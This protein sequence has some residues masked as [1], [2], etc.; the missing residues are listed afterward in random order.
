MEVSGPVT[1]SKLQLQSVRQLQQGQILLPTVPAR[2]QTRAS[3]P[4]QATAVRFLTHCITMGAPAAWESLLVSG[5]VPHQK[6]I[7]NK[8]NRIRRQ[9]KVFRK[10]QKDGKQKMVQTT[11]RSQWLTQPTRIHEED[12]SISGLD[13]CVKDSALS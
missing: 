9:K 13:Q 12:G 11:K 10:Q 8:Q 2:D 1:E 7:K 6:K 4:T 3:T 5:T